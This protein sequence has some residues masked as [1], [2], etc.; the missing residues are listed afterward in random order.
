LLTAF[1]AIGVLLACAGIYGVTGRS[2]I[3]RQ[4]ES[5]VRLALGA[6]ASQ[7]WW[8][9]ASRTL[10]ALGAGA[11]AGTAVA[12]LLIRALPPFLPEVA[13]TPAFTAI[14]AAVALLM[15]AGA[16]AALIPARRAAHVDP[17]L[18]LRGH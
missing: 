2:V 11:A 18:A 10:A 5:G 12:T 17:I 14:S 4:Q 13:G 15:A 9:A 7:V 3:E 1:A 6:T 8:T 16:A